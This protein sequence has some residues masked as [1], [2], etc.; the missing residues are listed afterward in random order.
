MTRSARAARWAA[1]LM[2][3]PGCG[4][5]LLTAV[6]AVAATAPHRAPA[7]TTLSLG[8]AAATVKTSN[9]QSWLMIVSDSTLTDSLSAGIVRAVAGGTG[10]EEHVW[11]FGV[12]ASTLTFST[13]TG[14]GTLKAGSQTSPVATIDLTF[15]ATSHQA[16]SCSSGSETIY[17]GTLSGQAELVTGLTGGGTVGGTSVSFT[18][19]GS[20]PRISVDSGCVPVTDDCVAAKVFASGAAA[21]KPE[22]GGVTVPGPGKSYELVSVS[23]RVALS[24]PAG[25]YRDDVALVHVSPPSWDPKTH[26]LSVTTTSSG[27]VTGSATL[28][29]GKATTM[30]LPCSYAGKSYTIKETENTTASYASPKG[31]TITGHTSLTGK[32]AAPAARSGATYIITTVTAK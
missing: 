19:K 14:T 5:A 29:G 7:A 1:H 27:I 6:P 3:I 20:A 10:A 24:S 28:S 9:G 2:L 31:G 21:G 26:V 15:K 23:R 18:G 30:S 12:T 16:A 25:A 22:A 8:N 11:N 17:T 4:L 32:L 13:S